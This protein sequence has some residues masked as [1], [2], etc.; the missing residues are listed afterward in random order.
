MPVLPAV[1]VY[2]MSKPEPIDGLSDD[3][4]NLLIEGLKAL[5]RERG[6]AWNVACDAAVAN[7]KRQPSLRQF[8]IDDIKRLARRLGGSAA[9]THWLEE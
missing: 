9:H 5:R 7:G 3:E 4:R 2:V 6:Q 1:E 8:G